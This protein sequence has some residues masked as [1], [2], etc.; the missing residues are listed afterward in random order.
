[1]DPLEL[2]EERHEIQR[3]R[4]SS[5]GDALPVFHAS[6]LD[7]PENQHRVTE[8]KKDAKP[9]YALREVWEM[10]RDATTTQ[11]SASV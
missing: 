7:V 11:H 10:S 3:H 2:R 8:E 6:G 1:M 9:F 4:I 5:Y